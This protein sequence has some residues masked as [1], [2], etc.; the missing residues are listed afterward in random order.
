MLTHQQIS[1]VLKCY[2]SASYFIENYFTVHHPKRG[3]I[4]L[5]LYPIQLDFIKHLTGDDS[6]LTL[7]SRMVGQTSIICGY[8]LWSVIFERKSIAI[9]AGNRQE[10]SEILELIRIAFNALPDFLKPAVMASNRTE[11]TLMYG[12]KVLSTVATETALRGLSLN[13]I[14]VTNASHLSKSQFES[15]W[16]T[17]FPALCSGNG[18]IVMASSGKVPGSDFERLWND[19]EFNYIKFLME[20]NS[21]PSRD[22]TFKK[23]MIDKLGEDAWYHDFKVS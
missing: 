23:S 6:F 21:V 17:T 12:G 7:A 10:S 8:V 5:S 9:I 13:T 4:P 1:E 15:V 2:E 19:P 16:M 20:W 3:M 14:L 22:E 11:L 18:K